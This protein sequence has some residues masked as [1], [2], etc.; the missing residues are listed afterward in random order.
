MKIAM[1]CY[2]LPAAQSAPLSV[3]P[4]ADQLDSC[5][6]PVASP[7]PYLQMLFSGERPGG[8][9]AAKKSAASGVDLSSPLCVEELAVHPVTLLIRRQAA[10]SDTYRSVGDV[11][12]RYRAMSMLK[13]PRTNVLA[14]GPGS[15][16]SAAP[17]SSKKNKKRKKRRDP[18]LQRAKA[19]SKA[20]QLWKV[21]LTDPASAAAP[22]TTSRPP[23]TERAGG[24]KSSAQL[25]K[26][27]RNDS[28]G[29]GKKC[30]LTHAD[31]VD[32]AASAVVSAV[33][34]VDVGEIQGQ[35][36]TIQS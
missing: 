8:S 16:A 27:A 2:V 13:K 21:L 34:S 15:S 1:L 3:S 18:A 12:A 24:D 14:A 9:A 31:P 25:K 4:D 35:P 6:D 33:V 28:L 22:I 36:L 10:K 23:H 26:S 29:G 11:L 32:A 30:K 5:N 20:N 7:S 17:S 19:L